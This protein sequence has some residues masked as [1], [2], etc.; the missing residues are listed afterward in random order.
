[1]ELFS[2]TPD[3]LERRHDE[4]NAAI[5]E[6]VRRGE[7]EPA[8]ES[9]R[10]LVDFWMRKGHLDEGR[11]HLDRLLAAGDPPSN[12][13]AAGLSGAG[14]LA[15][16]QG[17]DETARRLFEESAELA[18]SSGDDAVLAS[19]LGGLS[20]VALRAGD[21]A[22]T[23]ELA[24]GALDLVSGEGAEYSP[25][26]MLA[27]AARGEGD[28]ARA[29]EL[30]GETLAL[31]RRLGLRA[32]EAGELLNLGYVAL[33]LGNTDL[34]IERFRESLEIGA[35][36]EDDYLLP[37]F[38]LGAASSA[39]LR[40]DHGEAARLLAAAKAAFDRTGAAIDP[41]SAEEYEEVLTKARADLGNDFEDA[42]AE[43]SRLTLAEA[44]DRARS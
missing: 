10:A 43:G 3:E 2:L 16:R 14:V 23:R 33:H 44:V 20:R 22:Q 13:R 39:L 25:R 36:L 8:L 31:T 41:G 18:R 24:L 11:R 21:P 42:W 40:G 5:E 38:V 19:A 35:E 12:L 17:D 1:M 26:H 37:Y 15:F 29:E 34:A 4:L 9:E 30:Y 28:Y 7:P 27:A 6:L 32:A